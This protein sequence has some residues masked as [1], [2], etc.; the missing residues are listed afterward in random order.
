MAKPYKQNAQFLAKHLTLGKKGA[1][2]WKERDGEEPTDRLFNSRYPGLEA[3]SK[4][5]VTVKGRKFKIK[6][7]IATL[8][9]QQRDNKVKQ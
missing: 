2:I 3:G 7:V 9:K 5:I 6:K 4:G 1:L 8:R